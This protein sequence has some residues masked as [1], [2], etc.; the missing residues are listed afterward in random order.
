MFRAGIFLLPLVAFAQTPPPEVDQALR[1]RATEFLQAHVDGNFRK[2]YDF[3]A[4]DTKDYYFGAQKTR[5]NSFKIDEIRYSDDFT[6]ADVKITAEYNVSIQGRPLPVTNP[7]ILKWQIENEKWF[8]H[9]DP[10]S[11]ADTPMGWSDWSAA[12]MNSGQDAPPKLT[13]EALAQRAHEILTQSGIDKSEVTL[14][15][16]KASS[17][18]VVYHNALPGSVRVFVEA[19][20]KLEGFHAELDKTDVGA[21]ANVVLKLTYDPAADSS[22][23]AAGSLVHLQL[24]IEPFDRVFPIDVRF[25]G[26]KQEPGR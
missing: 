2:A 24:R 8:W 7:A 13:D 12:K 23:K 15:T 22:G 6:K 10:K 26:A 14:A 3:V 9:Y 18:Q 21:G 11:I 1:A 20:A 25:S 16:D 17:D 4:E 19:G 5:Y